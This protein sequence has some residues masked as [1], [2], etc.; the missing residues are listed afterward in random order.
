MSRKANPTLIGAFVLGGVLI[1]V[2]AVV[3]FGSGRFFR[4]TGAFISFFEGSVAGL[5]V[6]APVKF[7]GIEV[8]EVTDV[9]LDIPGVD[10]ASG[11]VRIAVVYELDRGRLEARGATVRL[12]DPFNIDTLHALG[13]RAELST[14]SLVTG[15]KYIA[16]DFDPTNPLLTEPV[17]GAPYPEIPAVDTGL[18]RIQEALQG[19]I[20]DLG[21]VPLDSLVNIATES[22]AQIGSLASSPELARGIRMLPSSVEGLNAVVAD[23][24]GLMVS[25]DSSLVPIRD[26]VLATAQQTTSAMQEL[27][28][29]LQDVGAALE[30]TSPASV[31]FEEAMQEL[32]AASRALR[33]LAEYLER[34]PSSILRGKPGGTQ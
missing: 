24:R 26:G 18:D 6:G 8:G 5:D 27:E 31:R 33:D 1:A 32:S 29:T 15:R 10:R 12:A 34:N 28:S 3:A 9:L 14:E 13:I 19:I 4:D 17:P 20:A 30:P 11:D 22:F 25:V 2:A 16:L 7:R 21:R 23:L